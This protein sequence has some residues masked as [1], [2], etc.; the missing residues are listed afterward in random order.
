MVREIKR[1]IKAEGATVVSREDRGGHQHLTV[2]HA[3]GRLQVL[4]TGGSPRNVD[5]TIV[6]AVQAVRRFAKGAEP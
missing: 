2:R 3:D 4:V 1:R 6:Y 5:A